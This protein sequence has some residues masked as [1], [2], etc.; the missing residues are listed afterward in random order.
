MKFYFVN[1]LTLATVRTKRGRFEELHLIYTSIHISM[2]SMYLVLIAAF[3]DVC[4]QCVANETEALTNI[5]CSLDSCL[6]SHHDF[7]AR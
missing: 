1:K 5:D 4:G 6:R 2:F 3:Y 7:C